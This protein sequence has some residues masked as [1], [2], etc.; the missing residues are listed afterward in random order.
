MI[1]FFEYQ[2]LRFKKNHL[3][4]LVALAKADGHFHDKEK[5]YLYR[6]GEKYQLKPQQI[7]RIIEEQGAADIQVPPDHHKKVA[8]LYDTVGMMLADGMIDEKEMDFCRNIFSRFGYRED[9]ISTMI[10]AHESG[11]L[12][13]PMEWEAF[14]EKVKDAKHE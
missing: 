10:S 14:V 12:E 8:F 1:G 4:S 9:L 11:G 7:K 2:Y 5:D 3:R 13:E 6:I